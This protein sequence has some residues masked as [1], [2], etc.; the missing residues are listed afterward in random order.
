MSHSSALLSSCAIGSAELL[1][2]LSELLLRLQG[3]TV[4]LLR[5]LARDFDPQRDDVDLLLTEPQRTAF[6]ASAFE[7]SAAG[8]F[9]IRIR[10]GTADKIQMVLWN[11]ECTSSLT[12]DF[13]SAFSQLPGHRGTMIRADR[14]LKT[15]APEEPC[16]QSPAEPSEVTLPGTSRLPADIDFC[17]LVLHLA[18]KKKKLTNPVVRERLL[19]AFNR[20]RTLTLIEAASRPCLSDADTLLQAAR[21][22]LNSRSIPGELV[23]MAEVYLLKRISPSSADSRDAALVSRGNRNLL[24]G[25]RRWWM[26]RVPC[27]AIVGSDGAGKSSVCM[28]LTGSV[29]AGRTKCAAKKLYRRSL[30][31]QILS[32][33][34]KRVSGANRGQFDDQV[35][36]WITLRASMSLWLRIALR[37]SERAVGQMTARRTATPGLPTLFAPS[38]REALVLD[39]SVSSFLIRD[40]KTETPQLHWSA[41]WLER[42][43]PPVTTVLLTVP[44]G[45]LVERRQEMTCHGHQRYQR[46]LFQQALRQQPSDVIIIANAKTASDAAELIQLIHCGNVPATAS[47]PRETAA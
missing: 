1:S 17:L 39:R 25:V 32:G 19:L 11:L 28:R 16:R 41:R 15:L 5:P 24:T 45:Q 14:L 35:A 37:A 31:Y 21:P 46:L 4:V 8:K 34:V 9:H 10:Q 23:R 40:R 44:F 27:L 12:I 36:P 38:G 7:A 42:W 22:I 6:L 26:Q 43:I 30:L 3:D 2:A 33:V 29:P 18:S 13:W 20:L 47:T